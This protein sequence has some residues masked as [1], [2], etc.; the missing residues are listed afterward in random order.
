MAKM[1][2]VHSFATCTVSVLFLITYPLL[3][4]ICLNR[5]DKLLKEFWEQ[6][7]EVDFGQFEALFLE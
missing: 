6:I 7:L 1:K 5:G 2:C 3:F 4:Q